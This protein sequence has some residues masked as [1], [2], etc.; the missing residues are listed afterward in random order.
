[1]DNRHTFR[2]KERISRQ[3][4]INV[5]FEKGKSFIVYPLRVV[6]LEGQP[7]SGVDAAVLIRVPKKRIK[8]AVGR[9]RIKR[10]IREA[11]RLNKHLL[12]L[13]LQEKGKALLTAFL[14]VGK[15]LPDWQTV[16]TAMVKVLNA[17]AQRL[18]ADYSE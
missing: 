10:L 16:E 18:S 1:L 3:K 2:K 14:F 11:Y 13:E 8:R 15:E 17:L 6:Y 5:L 12:L 7:V 4:E 9:N